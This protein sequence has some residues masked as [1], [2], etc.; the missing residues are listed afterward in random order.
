VRAGEHLNKLTEGTDAHLFNSRVVTGAV[1]GYANW[2]ENIG[3]RLPF[4]WREGPQWGSAT[5]AMRQRVAILLRDF[6][7]AVNAACPARGQP[8]TLADRPALVSGQVWAAVV[9]TSEAGEGGL[10]WD[11]SI[12]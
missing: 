2:R 7:P 10:A 9:P 8:V 5:Y 6:I 12:G 4:Y 1:A 11:S 3:R